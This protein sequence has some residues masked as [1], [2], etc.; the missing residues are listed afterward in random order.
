MGKLSCSETFEKVS[1]YGIE[2]QSIGEDPGTFGVRQKI[3]KIL[4][5]RGLAGIMKMG[6]KKMH[7][8][9]LRKKIYQ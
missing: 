9:R 4:S 6:I 1:A 2:L 8:K 7:R 5:G 3:V